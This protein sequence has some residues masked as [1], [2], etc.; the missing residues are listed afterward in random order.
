MRAVAVVLLLAVALAGCGETIPPAPT[1]AQAL[2]LKP[3][4]PRLADL[5]ETACKA[6]HAIPGTGA[7]LVHDRAAWDPRW[8][9][10]EAVLLDHTIQGYKA[11]PALGQCVA[12][13]P[14]DFQGLIRFMAGREDPAS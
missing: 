13:A 2:M 10:G 9:Q 7:P 4:D 6:C 3:A 8:K 1:P 12:C 14:A 5:Y 11:M